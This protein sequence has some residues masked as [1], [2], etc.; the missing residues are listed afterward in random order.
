[1]SRGPSR[2]IVDI[3]G[4]FGKGVCAAAL[5]IHAPD[6]KGSKGMNWEG[7]TLPG[8]ARLRSDC[9]YHISPYDN[10]DRRTQ[11]VGNDCHKQSSSS[12]SRQPASKECRRAPILLCSQT[13]EPFSIP[14]CSLIH[15]RKPGGIVLKGLRFGKWSFATTFATSSLQ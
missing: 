2:L 8:G 6:K 4:N 13:L 1:M 11:A 9:P 10:M 15:T 14:G 7:H 5:P 12:G 3:K